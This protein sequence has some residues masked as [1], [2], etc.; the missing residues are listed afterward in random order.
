MIVRLRVHF[1]DGTISDR[2][3]FEQSIKLGRDPEGPLAFSGDAAKGVSW[4]HAELQIKPTGVILRDLGSSNGTWVNDQKLEE[5]REIT[6]GLEFRLGATGPK[7]VVETIEVV[8]AAVQVNV[9]PPSLVK[10]LPSPSRTT[11]RPTT[12]AAAPVAAPTSSKL[13]IIVSSVV[14]LIVVVGVIFGLSSKPKPDPKETPKEVAA[15]ID[16]EPK[17]PPKIEPGKIEIPKETPKKTQTEPPQKNSEKSKSKDFPRPKQKERAPQVAV[18]KEVGFFVNNNAQL[19]PILLQGVPTG[20]AAWVRLQDGDRVLSNQTLVSL[21]GYR[22]TIRLNNK[23]DIQLWGHL[24]DFGDDGV[25]IFE[26]AVI[27]NPLEEKSGVDVDLILDRGRV[28]F[29]GR[30]EPTRIRIQFVDH[31]FELILPN[32]KSKVIA[33]LSFP[34]SQLKD[35]QG[36][37][38]ME[39]DAYLGLLTFGGAKLKPEKGNAIDLPDGTR[40]IWDSKKKEPGVPQKFQAKPIWYRTDIIPAG[41]TDQEKKDLTTTMASLIDWSKKYLNMDWSKKQGSKLDTVSVVDI[42]KTQLSEQRQLQDEQLRLQGLLFYAAIDEVAFLVRY[43][44]DRGQSE[45]DRPNVR[46]TAATAIRYWAR[47]SSDH[48]R[49]L[50]ELFDREK[51][52]KTKAD[53]LLHLLLGPANRG[54]TEVDGRWKPILGEEALLALLNHDSLMVRQLACQRLTERTFFKIQGD[55][56]KIKEIDYDP[57]S[58]EEKRTAA[59]DRWKKIILK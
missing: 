7:I 2:L 19:P 32:A 50:K 27:F 15:K 4:E 59:I 23:V 12:V 20:D 36:E 6:A 45:G 8:A 52:P 43:L 47:T 46:S 44:E 55:G 16:I 18:Q 3:S 37:P 22:S 25:P 48:A 24:P 5:S 38:Q 58:S 35:P 39:L 26:S 57:T 49:Q 33:E 30:P 9:A 1:P 56:S 17:E 51:F 28:Q 10:S 11:P 29:F 40:T 41:A 13:P 31:Q 42:I 53:V 54:N 34:G 14:G 21:P